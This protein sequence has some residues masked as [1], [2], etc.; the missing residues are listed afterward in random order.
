MILASPLI[1]CRCVIY[2]VRQARGQRLRERSGSSM[3]SS[4]IRLTLPKPYN[5]SCAC[6]TV[7][8]VFPI[9]CHFPPPSPSPLPHPAGAIFSSLSC[10][11]TADR[12]VMELL[13]LRLLAKSF[14]DQWCVPHFLSFSLSNSVC[15]PVLRM[16]R[17]TVK[18]GCVC[19]F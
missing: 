14:D 1:G 19:V 17:H 16:Q 4:I 8:S 15:V 18:W 10:G 3:Q 7:S 6:L 13:L 12:F 2:N 11:N 9:F 5:H